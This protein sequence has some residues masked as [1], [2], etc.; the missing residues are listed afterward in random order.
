MQSNQSVHSTGCSIG[1]FEHSII[2][3]GVAE[4]VLGLLDTIRAFYV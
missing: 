4:L 3:G 2:D 1:I